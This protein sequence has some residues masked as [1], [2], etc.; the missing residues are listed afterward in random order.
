MNFRGSFHAA[1]ARVVAAQV[2]VVAPR[3]NFHTNPQVSSRAVHAPG[4]VARVLDVVVVAVASNRG[5]FSLQRR[6]HEIESPLSKLLPYDI[7]NTTRSVHGNFGESARF[8]Q[9]NNQC[10]Y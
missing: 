7:P 4:L 10:S 5:S 9:K 2:D 1:R 6:P 8:I 3:W